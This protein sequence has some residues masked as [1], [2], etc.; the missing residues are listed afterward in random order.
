MTFAS[1]ELLRGNTRLLGYM[2]EDGTFQFLM[3][4][5]MRSFPTLMDVWLAW[6]EVHQG[7]QPK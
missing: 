3:G 5:E 1:I 6:T 7:L 4:G 2:M